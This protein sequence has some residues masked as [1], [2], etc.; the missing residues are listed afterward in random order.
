MQI[1]KKLEDVSMVDVLIIIMG[2][3]I[4]GVGS[5][6]L[7]P[8]IL[9]EVVAEFPWITPLTGIIF[10]ISGGMIFRGF[11]PSHHSKDKKKEG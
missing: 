1:R 9:P 8:R 11:A 10:A 6:F 7:L 2:V 3:I 5:L 4:F